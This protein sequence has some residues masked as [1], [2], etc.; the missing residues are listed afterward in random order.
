MALIF[1]NH[2]EVT[3]DEDVLQQKII[4]GVL[5]PKIKTKKV[6][7]PIRDV[8][9]MEQIVHC[10]LKQGLIRREI[11]EI[12]GISRSYYERIRTT[13]NPN[14]IRD[15]SEQEVL[16][17]IEKF[18]KGVNLISTQSVK[19][20]IYA[21]FDQGL[22]LQEVKE[23]IEID[24]VYA[25][26]LRRCYEKTTERAVPTTIAKRLALEQKQ[27]VEEAPIYINSKDQVLDLFGRGYD[28]V[29]QLVAATGLCKS[30]IRK[31][32]RELGL[33]ASVPPNQ[34]KTATMKESVTK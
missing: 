27:S 32:L 13:Y 23:I 5:N 10:L 25:F 6:P 12:T 20:K 26:Q 31:I 7:S 4:E 9:T 16:S 18:E 2:K 28:T 17:T 24:I 34:H 21:L 1:Y 3:M 19:G 14:N 8:I 11:V 15:L 30:S 33:K 22:S 29:N